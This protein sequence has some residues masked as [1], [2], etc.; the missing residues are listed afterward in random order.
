MTTVVTPMMLEKILITL[1]R[2]LIIMMLA[3]L[4]RAL[5]LKSTF[6][7][8][9]KHFT[10]MKSNQHF[11]FFL[12]FM[13]RLN[14]IYWRR[15]YCDCMFIFVASKLISPEFN[16]NILKFWQW[17]EVINRTFIFH[18]MLTGFWRS[19]APSRSL[20]EEKYNN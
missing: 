11:T 20:L 14:T 5:T 1:I 17:S 4:W 2:M 18:T 13:I 8:N 6:L 3:Y 9:T 16:A 10:L 12:I 19:L 15:L 7:S